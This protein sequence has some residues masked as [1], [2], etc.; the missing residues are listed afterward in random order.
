MKSTLCFIHSGHSAVIRIRSKWPGVKCHLHTCVRHGEDHAFKCQN[1]FT[2]CTGSQRLPV[3]PGHWCETTQNS[4]N[5]IG[6]ERLSITVWYGGFGQQSCALQLDLFMQL[7]YVPACYR[8]RD[9]P[10]LLTVCP[11]LYTDNIS[12][13][14]DDK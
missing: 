3:A 14:S 4:P 8:T 12:C 11:W 10:M 13:T 9:S 1:I 7:I 2:L 6:F 5:S